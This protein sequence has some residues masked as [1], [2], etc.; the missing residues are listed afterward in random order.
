MPRLRFWLPRP[1]AEATS[2]GDSV[3]IPA[4]ATRYLNVQARVELNAATTRYAE[5]LVKEAGRLEANARGVAGDPEI[6]TTMI[7]DAE[8]VLRR[9]YSRQQSRSVLVTSCQV[10]AI[11]GGI[12][13]G[14][15][16]D[17][18]KLQDPF[19]MVVFVAVLAATI[20]ASVIAFLKD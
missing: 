15:L 8:M 1:A 16:A 14:L 3:T 9:G 17:M 19:T 6:T 13:T 11:V 7:H 5:D 12:A 2:E 18:E 20:T 4:E 10:I